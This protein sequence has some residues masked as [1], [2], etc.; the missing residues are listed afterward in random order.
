MT[1][2]YNILAP[3]TTPIWADLQKVIAYVSPYKIGDKEYNDGYVMRATGSLFKDELIQI[4]S[5][6]GDWLITE[7]PPKNAIGIMVWEGVCTNAGIGA[8]QAAEEDWEPIFRGVWRRPTNEE[9]QSLLPEWIDGV[10]T[11]CSIC[12]KPMPCCC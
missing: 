3:C 7:V 9:L 10:D 4:G 1:Q 6:L 11:P 12:G 2:T 8:T 5:E